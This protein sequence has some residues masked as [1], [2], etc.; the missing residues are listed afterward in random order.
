MTT[1][2]RT[3]LRARLLARPDEK[4]ADAGDWQR[5]LAAE[6]NQRLLSTIIAHN[7]RSVADLTDLVGRS[8]PNVSR[9]LLSLVKAGL[10]ELRQNGRMSTPVVTELG[11]EK[12]LALE[13]IPES[14]TDLPTPPRSDNLNVSVIFDAPSGSPAVVTGEL[15]I[16]VGLT[17]GR[18]IVG[19]HS[20]DITKLSERWTADWWRILCRRDAPYQLCDFDVMH[21]GERSA[22]TV[23]LTSWGSFVEMSARP[24][25][26]LEH[27]ANLRGLR[28][29]VEK[30][31]HDVDQ[32]ILHPVARELNS[33]GEYD[34]PIHGLLAWREDALSHAADLA[35]HRTA[36]ALDLSQE[37]KFESGA[38][39][40]IRQLIEEMPEEETRL[41]FASSLLVEDVR[42]ANCWIKGAL[43]ENGDRNR[44]TGLPNIAE[45]CRYAGKIENPRPHLRGIALAKAVRARLCLADR[46]VGGL[47]GLSAL[48]GSENFAVDA[49]APGELLGFQ[50]CRSGVPTV[51]VGQGGEPPIFRLAR[52]IGDYV[53]YGGAAA[54]ISNIRPGRQALGRAFAAEF[55]APA[56][57]VIA[58]VDEGYDR[59]RIARHFGTTPAV[60]RHQYENNANNGE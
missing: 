57:T 51:V 18:T 34:R 44:L 53:A 5:V 27:D 39:I 50:A 48:F 29:S 10:V 42:D 13:I 56:A 37:E 26:V 19:R 33:R 3:E 41:E 32:G 1:I 60:I 30:F 25:K 24:Q 4:G 23:L 2:D 52:G 21:A 15:T 9:S 11:R 45:H 54:T 31:T 43:D 58:M 40:L 12:A 14:S 6:G 38:E 46:P 20:G 16:R 55:L 8:Q 28:M 36:G 35:F 49:Q 7:P 17:K 47:H 22:M 59:Q